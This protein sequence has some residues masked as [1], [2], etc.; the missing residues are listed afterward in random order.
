MKSK[1]TM[2]LRRLALCAAPLMLMWGLAVTPARAQD[3]TAGAPAQTQTPAEQQLPEG[4]IEQLVATIALY[5]DPL[6]TQVLMASTYPLEVVEAARWSHDNSMVNGHA[7]AD[8]MQAQPWDPS[9]KA[10]TAVPQTLQMM[11]DK[12]NWTQQLGD[13]FLAQQQDVLAAV[14]KLRAEAQAA[15]NLQSTPQQVVTVAPA[16]VDVAA[17]NV[18]P[19]IV[20]EPVNPDVYYVPVYDPAVAYGTWGYPDYPPF[21]WSP[22]GFVASNVVSFAA[23]V[24]VGSA[25]WGGCDWW[26]HN[27]IINVNRFNVFNHTNINFANNTWIHNPEHRHGV[28]YQNASLT[29]RFGTANEAAAREAFRDRADTGHNDV[30][31]DHADVQHPDAAHGMAGDGGVDA[32]RIVPTMPD[33]LNDGGDRRTD[34]AMPERRDFVQPRGDARPQAMRPRAQAFRPDRRATF[35]G[36]RGRG[37]GGRRRL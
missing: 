4:Q 9:V 3:A 5:P 20:I 29:R 25:I 7:L 32:R 15:G 18:P 6:L 2:A 11:S 24:A 1:T 37:G 22:P 17:S 35:S 16:P 10:L 13:A 36:F 26:Q 14:Q 19:P 28:P 31:R 33:R 34:R 12:L 21:Y 30:F 8:A 27:V 23:G